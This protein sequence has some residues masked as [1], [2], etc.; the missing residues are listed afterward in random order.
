MTHETLGSEGEAGG[1][2]GLVETKT[3]RL[4]DEESPLV[5]ESG[6]TLAPVDIAYETY[7][8]LDS[9]RSN[10]II[11]SHALTGDAHVAGHH[12]EP[13]TE[14]WWDS[15]I[16]PRKPIDTDRYFVVCS[17]LLGG[18]SGS[19]GPSS[20]DPATGK[21]YGLRFPYF[22]IRDLVEVQRRLLRELGI[23]HLYAGMGGSMGGM[24]ILQWVLD[25][26]DEI[27]NALLICAT[28]R[29]T[30]ENIAF[31][32][33]ARNSIM[34]DV[35]FQNGDYYGTGLQPDSGLSV[36]RMLA[37]IT[38]LSGEALEHKFG[39]ERHP[40]E[41]AGPTL[42]VDFQVESYLDHQGE[43][44]LSRFD[45]NTYLYLSRVMDY[46][47]PFADED[48]AVELLRKT[49]ARFLVVSFD[50][51]WRFSTSHSLEIARVLR[52]AGRDVVC[53]E[54]VSPWGHDSF[55][56]PVPAYHQLVRD[57]LSG[58]R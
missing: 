2:V 25:H 28:S 12:G 39:R 7:G 10:A 41:G 11:V 20:I 5:L 43:K 33:V 14:G 53:E 58:K 1:S 29:L 38:Y 26:P 54:I 47:D 27:S 51:D 13:K 50:T 22:T 46:F 48:Q 23:E 8:A 16:G 6:E 9:E 55:L 3:V 57:F 37:H 52:T 56:L 49:S 40:S 31:S 44:F 21:P 36:A 4:Y 18:C 35:N 24:Q 19:T 42:G 32:S 34:R 17:N 30:P 45:A 15:M